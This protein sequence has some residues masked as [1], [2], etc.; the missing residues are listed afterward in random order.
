MGFSVVDY[1]VLLVYLVGITIFGMRFRGGQRTVKDYFLGN[2][3]TAW[4]VISLSIVA[5][6]R[7]ADADR[8]AGAGLC[9][10]RDPSRADRPRIFRSSSG[11]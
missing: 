3:T 10:T 8:R 9:R 11:I 1:L 7:D 2:R 6:R 5:R 4:W